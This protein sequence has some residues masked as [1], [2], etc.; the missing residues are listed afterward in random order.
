MLVL[1]GIRYLLATSVTSHYDQLVERFGTQT[2]AGDS[3]A[4]R[5][6]VTGWK[7][8]KDSNRPEVSS[9]VSS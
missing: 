1:S 7:V 3:N 8:A 6:Q 2:V 4:T 5:M 9:E